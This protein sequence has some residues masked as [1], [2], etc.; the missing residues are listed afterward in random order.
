M[1]RPKYFCVISIVLPMGYDYL[2]YFFRSD[3]FG[4]GIALYS[5]VVRYLT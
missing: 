4:T 5:I 2:Y 1:S 3:I